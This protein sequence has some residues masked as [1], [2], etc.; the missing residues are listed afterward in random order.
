MSIA[1]IWLVGLISYYGVRI[2]ARDSMIY[3]L[4]VFCMPLV[5]CALPQITCIRS[6]PTCKSLHCEI[7]P[8]LPGLTLHCVGVSD[9]CLLLCIWLNSVSGLRVSSHVS[10]Y[11]HPLCSNTI[12]TTTISIGSPDDDEYWRDFRRRRWSSLYVFRRL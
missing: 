7:R 8:R 11:V 1:K 5:Y 4:V 2:L 9:L 3:F 10:E 6:G 12:S